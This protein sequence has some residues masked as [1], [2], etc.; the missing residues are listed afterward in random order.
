[1]PQEKTRYMTVTRPYPRGDRRIP[2]GRTIAVA[3]AV[4]V[5]MLDA[6]PPFGREATPEE[7]TAAGLEPEVEIDATE[8][9]LELARSHAYDLA[10]HVGKGSGADGRITKGDVVGWIEARATAQAEPSA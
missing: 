2:A 7:V 6:R 5:A 3:T 4:A 9:A 1:M 8:G 10:P